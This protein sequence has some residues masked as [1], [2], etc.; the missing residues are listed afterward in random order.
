MD[1]VSP[2]ATP[3]V[4]DGEICAFVALS[5]EPRRILEDYTPLWESLDARLGRA[6]WKERGVDAFLDGDVPYGATSG[7]RLAEDAARILLRRFEETGQQ[8]P[9]RLLEIGAGS[10][11]FAKILLDR[12]ATLA[13]D[14]YAATRFVVTDGSK[15]M[16]DGMR[17]LGLTEAHGDHVSL[18]Q[19]DA[20]RP[21]APQL[22]AA[23]EAP[24]G[25][26][27]VF[28]NYLLDSLPFA[29]RAYRDE[30]AWEMECR[31]GLDD[32]AELARYF[33]GDLDGLRAAI[34]SLD[35]A[36]DPRLAKLHKA[37]LIDARW[38]PSPR[39]NAP[40]PE[41][42]PAI[43]V[44]G[45][46]E[47]TTVS[48]DNY[49]A[50]ALLDELARALDPDGVLLFTDYGRAE[51]PEPGEPLEYQQF[52]GSIAIG[53]NFAQ[54]DRWAAAR[55]GIW[56]EKPNVDPDSLMTRAVTKTQSEVVPAII[57][58][59]CSSARIDALSS[60]M[61]A[62]RNLAKARRFEAAR[63]SYETA[64]R[65]QPCNWNALEEI[66]TFLITIA[67]DADAGLA[68]VTRVLELNPASPSAYRLMGRAL[69][70][71]GEAERAESALR[72]ALDLSPVSFAARVDLV[73]VLLARF[74]HRE[75]LEIVAE[76]L[77][78]DIGCEYRDELIEAQE[79]IL[80]DL[81][82]QA[83]DDLARSINRIRRHRALPGG[84]AE[85]SAENA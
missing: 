55:D 73:D 76:G 23:C 34:G 2:G 41:T 28:A 27:G 36:P 66:A 64:L 61:A 84:A 82:L 58:E 47:V 53:L 85:E 12:L 10:G 13:P 20:S 19:L 49:G 31:A 4:T 67:E 45:E 38:A 25:Y 79:K 52:G 78:L 70:D 74:A 75:A 26:H 5:P 11:I 21:I 15:T 83:K 59:L 42:L 35:D 44:Q 63:W 43:A 7:G 68:L 37:L 77:A 32:K 60:A 8:G 48:L 57:D 3:K 1:K 51:E 40:F 30:D 16:L 29:I 46:E 22:E 72:N 56:L 14:I 9:V 81:T 39:R 71:K 18:V 50:V 33:D 24:K 17:E 80:R 54:F 6:F 62:A 65:L 69:W